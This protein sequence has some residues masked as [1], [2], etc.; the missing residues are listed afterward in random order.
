[1]TAK[2]TASVNMSKHSRETIL[3]KGPMARREDPGTF[4]GG[5]RVKTRWGFSIHLFTLYP[6]LTG[7]PWNLRKDP[8]RAMAKMFENDCPR[9]NCL[10]CKLE[11]RR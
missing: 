1:M 8:E 9:L 10:E 2:N 4:A 6:C 11:V 3:N 5:H 7:G